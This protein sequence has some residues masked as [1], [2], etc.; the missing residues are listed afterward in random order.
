MDD[1]LATLSA[2]G[3]FDP[4]AQLPAAPDPWDYMPTPAHRDRA[5][6]ATAEMIAAE[7]A[8]VARVGARV[9]AS[10]AAAA[11]A[12]AVL[13]AAEL[14]EQVVVTGYGTSE[15]AAMGVAAQVKNPLRSR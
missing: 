7:P 8:L 3:A 4:E 15:H 13:K 9:V 14:G 11:L 10:G 6:W 2:R 5:P 12:A 1:L